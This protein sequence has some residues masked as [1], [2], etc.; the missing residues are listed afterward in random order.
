MV[1]VGRLRYRLLAEHGGSPLIAWVREGRDLSQNQARK[2]IET[3]KVYLDGEP[4]LDWRT[5]VRQGADVSVDTDRKKPARL[6]VLPDDAVVYSDDWILVA[7]KPAGLVSVPPTKTGEPTLQDLLAARARKLREHSAVVPV[8]RL[9][10]ETRG[11]M[12]FARG[13]A[14]AAELLQQFR[15]HSV[16]REYY[17]VVE[18]AVTQ[19]TVEGRIDVSR[20]GFSDTRVSRTAITQFEPV[21][22]SGALSL[23]ICR[24]GTG[25]YHQIRIV[26][27]Q[28]GAP[29]VGERQH[30]PAGFE[31]CVISREL[32]L[33]SFLLDIQHPGSGRRMRWQL[34][35]DPA[36]EAMLARGRL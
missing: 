7:N 23:V 15:E 24:P 3:G 30:L 19:S 2:L 26:L 35:L 36:L 17:A 22:T 14:A 25:R 4:C 21:R 5:P 18:G 29:I 34:P 8:H 12:V 1:Q 31:P 33:Q 20:Q 11:L 9:D 6:Q 10:R 27:S 32:G 28:M 13:Q 16:H